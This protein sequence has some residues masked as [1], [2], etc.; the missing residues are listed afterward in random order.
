MVIPC[1]FFFSSRRR[2][3]RFDCDWSSDVCSSDLEYHV[4]PGYDETSLARLM[5]RH[6]LRI[7]RRGYYFRFFTPLATEFVS[8]AP[9]CHHRGVPG[10]RAPA[11]ADAT[12][13]GP[14]P[15]LRL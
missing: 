15:P 13:S 1:T 3:T 7:H 10:R 8:P 14:R 4:R 5:E 6:G 9:P 2:H 11:R 12:A